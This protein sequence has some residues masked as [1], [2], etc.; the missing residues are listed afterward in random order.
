MSKSMPYGMGHLVVCSSLRYVPFT[1]LT[2]RRMHACEDYETV[3]GREQSL[4]LQ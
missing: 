1:T 2:F 4:W 3:G